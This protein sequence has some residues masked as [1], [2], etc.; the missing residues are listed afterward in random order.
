M[1]Q[2]AAK[3]FLA[4]AAT[5]L[6]V[7]AIVFLMI[8]L[9]P[10]TVV[11]QL[12]GQSALVSQVTLDALR[13][14]FGLDQPL[15]VQYLRWMGGVIRG[16]LG[17]SWR[18]M[19]PVTHMI[20]QRFPIS[21][22]LAIAAIAVSLVVGIPLGVLAA[23]RRH[24]GTDG[25]VRVLSTIALAIPSFWQG[26]LLILFMSKYLGWLPPIEWIPFTRDP[27]ENLKIVALPALTLGTASAAMI[28]RMSRSA[29][30][31][32][33]GQEYIRTA[34]AKGL[35]E[36]VTLWRHALRNALI[37]V[38]TLAG[39]QMGYILAGIVVVE[40]V[41]SLPGLG[42]LLLNAIFQRDYPVVQGTVLF[43]AVWFLIIN[44]L[45]DVLYAIVDPR[46]RYD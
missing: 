20:G 38:I 31:D 23:S 14:F 39:V 17:T 29:L 25:W 18:S 1:T 12:L 46:I 41:F 30:L 8:R 10:G 9:I 34:R 3:R 7:S 42:R 13:S 27:V 28:T 33:L 21:L 36:R 15:H 37:P 40:D 43:I 35:S 6:G 45:V 5:L 19:Q 24:T 26:T 4:T 32:V 16:D 22:E 11:E 44:F 2:F